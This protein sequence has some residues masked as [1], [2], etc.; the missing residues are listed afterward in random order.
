VDSAS[1]PRQDGVQLQAANV[2]NRRR[3]GLPPDV[4]ATPGQPA[5]TDRPT[6]TRVAAAAD[7][8]RGAV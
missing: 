7:W 2:P 1:A 8:V 5:A 4:R 6:T 3:L